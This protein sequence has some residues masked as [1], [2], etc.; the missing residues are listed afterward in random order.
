ML[1]L[2][3]VLYLWGVV[4]VARRHPAHPWP[5]PPTAAF[6]AGLGVVGYATEGGIDAY[7]D[8]FFSVHISGTC[9]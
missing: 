9:C 4:R 5:W 3:A 1:V 2:A 7:D 8:V 6:L